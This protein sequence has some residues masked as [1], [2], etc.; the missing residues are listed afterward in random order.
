LKIEA[1]GF[2]MYGVI[3]VAA[4]VAA[5]FASPWA[6]LACLGAGALFPVL[7]LLVVRR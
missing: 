5:W 4:V 1:D 7:S 6:A 3:V 2:L